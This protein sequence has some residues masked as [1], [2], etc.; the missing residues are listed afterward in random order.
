MAN[1]VIIV[2]QHAKPQPDL[3]NFVMFLSAQLLKT[4][5][6]IQIITNN[7]CSFGEMETR[8]SH[9]KVVYKVCDHG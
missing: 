3:F 1:D 6:Q 7:H 4:Y 2:I 5:E 9:S 8:A